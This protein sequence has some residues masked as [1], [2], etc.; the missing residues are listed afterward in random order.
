MPH[1][2]YATHALRSLLQ[3]RGEIMGSVVRV[4]SSVAEVATAKGLMRVQAASS[5]RPGQRVRVSEGLAYQ[6]AVSS[7]KYAL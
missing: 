5:V 1:N 3:P 4:T 7:V 6:A 2:R